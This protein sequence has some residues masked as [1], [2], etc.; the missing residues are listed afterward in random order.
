MSADKDRS[1]AEVGEGILDF[2]AIFKAALDA[3]VEWFSVEQDRCPRPS[4]ESAKMSYRNIQKLE[5]DLGMQ[6]TH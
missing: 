3:N 1:F 5:S 2:T 4:L 6:R